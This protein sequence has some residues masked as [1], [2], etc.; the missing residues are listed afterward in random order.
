MKVTGGTIFKRHT[1]QLSSRPGG[2]LS[3][4]H[5]H[6]NH[7][8]GDVIERLTTAS[9][10]GH[11]FGLYE[12]KSVVTDAVVEDLLDTMD[13]AVLS[14]IVE[15]VSEVPGRYRFTHRLTQQVLAEGLTQTRRTILHARIGEALEELY[16]NDL[17]VH[18]AELAHHFGEAAPLTGTTK[19]IE[20]CILAGEHALATYA[21]EEAL[22]Q[23]QRAF[24]AKLGPDGPSELLAPGDTQDIDRQTAEILYGLGRSQRSTATSQMQ[25]AWATLSMAF[26]YNL[27]AGDI[28]QVVDVAEL[29]PVT[30]HKRTTELLAR[31]LNLVPS[32]SHF[33]GRLLSRYGNAL[34]FEKGDFDGALDAFHKALTIARD[35]H[36]PAL[37]MKTITNAA[38]LDGEHLRIHESLEKSLRTVE[39]ARFVPNPQAELLARFWAAT[40][41]YS[42]GESSHAIAHAAAWLDLA[43]R[44]KA[45]HQLATAIWANET[46]ARM[47]G[48]WDAARSYCEQGLELS[49]MDCRLLSSLVLIEFQA[50]DHKEG[51]AVLD[52]LFDVMNQEEEGADLEFALPAITVPLVVQ[53]AGSN[54]HLE[55]AQEAAQTVLSADSATPSLVLLARAGLALAAIARGDASKAYGQHAYLLPHKGTMLYGGLGSV[56]RM[57]ALISIISGRYEDADAHFKAAEG[58]CRKA[59]YWPELAWTTHDHVA[60]LALR[61]GQTNTHEAPTM[62]DETIRICE[63]LGMNALEEKAR[64][65]QA[66]L[67]A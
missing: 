61:D 60:S 48:D 42:L 32:G 54:S 34:N 16:G 1:S 66:L 63:E 14:G 2:T 22:R 43:D 11:E 59:C 24:E 39:L 20:Y 37:E 47:K 7:L 19:Q 33:E 50:G 57:L 4:R 18:T 29:L 26:E 52:R 25:K 3:L 31:A 38:C 40:A 46:L 23:F 17:M 64:S 67:A 45:P 65:H 5:S 58:F 28:K 41:H 13:Q 62:L 49:P 55:A 51:R 36:D 44:L 10:I 53:A 6:I 27:E 56:D 35:V 21:Y 12:V 15:E 8:P 9:V 30:E